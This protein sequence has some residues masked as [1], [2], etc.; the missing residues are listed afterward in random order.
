MME[1]QGLS[2]VIAR[3]GAIQ[4][5]AAARG[6]H[7]NHAPTLLALIQA[8]RPSARVKVIVSVEHDMH[9]MLPVQKGR[10]PL[11]AQRRNR[12]GCVCTEQRL[13]KHHE[14]P[15]AV[16]ELPQLLRQPFFLRCSPARFAIADI[17]IQT[18]KPRRAVFKC[19]VAFVA[20]QCEIREIQG[21]IVF[22]IPWHADQRNARNQWG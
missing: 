15:G 18:D 6:R 2:D 1:G 17:A 11:P 13:M 4:R 3:P 10:R 7:K 16:V 14:I 9:R 19:I 8:D 21:R 12:A 5:C 22:V 20:W